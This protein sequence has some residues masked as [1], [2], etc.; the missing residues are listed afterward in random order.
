MSLPSLEQAC[1]TQERAVPETRL[2]AA[3]AT[4]TVSIASSSVEAARRLLLGAIGDSTNAAQENYSS[5]HHANSIFAHIPTLCGGPIPHRL[6]VAKLCDFGSA[7]CRTTAPSAK[8]HG[9]RRSWA[10]GAGGSRRYC[11][12]EVARIMLAAAA[13]L[14]AV[15]GV[16]PEQQPNTVHGATCP[17][18]ARRPCGSNRYD[19]FPTDVWS[20][21]VMLFALTTGLKPF[22]CAHVADMHFRAFVCATQPAAAMHPLC[23]PEHPAWGEAPSD[24]PWAWPRCMSAQLIDLVSQCLQVDPNRRPTMAQVLEHAFFRVEDDTSNSP[25]SSARTDIATVGEPVERVSPSSSCERASGS[26]PQF[27]ASV[28]ASLKWEGMQRSSESL[29]VLPV[30]TRSGADS[31]VFP[32]DGTSDISAGG[33]AAV[34]GITEDESPPCTHAEGQADMLHSTAG[35]SGA[36]ADDTPLPQLGTICIQLLPSAQA[37]SRGGGSP[38]DA[39]QQRPR[40]KGVHRLLPLEHARRGQAIRIPQQS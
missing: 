4:D 18:E 23:E 29:L 35:M 17:H 15:T 9:G 1:A 34:Y 28:P 27:I 38:R 33:L 36:S 32:R 21:G 11:A 20:F 30:S 25:T 5:P 3:I 14:K 12:P 37:Q 2:G 40:G 6:A 19:P 7:L 26:T 22:R 13:E 39:A 8:G 10:H 24:K 31:W 16:E